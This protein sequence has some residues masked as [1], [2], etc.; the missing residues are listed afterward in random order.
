MKI[1]ARSVFQGRVGR[2][3]LVCAQTV[4]LVRI[5]AAAPPAPA[6]KIVGAPNGRT[7]LSAADFAGIA[8]VSVEAVDHDGKKAAFSGW[9]LGEVLALTGV[10]RGKDFRGPALATVVTASARDGY[11]VAFA[12]AELEPSVTGKVV[13]L[14]DVRDGKPL[15][16][17]EGPWRVVVPGEKRPARWIRQVASFA[18]GRASEEA[19]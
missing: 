2:I 1:R 3:A 17:S 10:P 4:L 8:R 15:S 11:R 14:A 12:L 5:A 7:A 9:P 6:L 18:I 16:D 13:L 19:K